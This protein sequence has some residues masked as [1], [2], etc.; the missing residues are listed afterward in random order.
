MRRVREQNGFFLK[1]VLFFFF[2][3][4]HD[5]D[6][7]SIR[8]DDIRSNRKVRLCEITNRMRTVRIVLYQL[9]KPLQ[10]L[11]II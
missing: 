8:C 7:F 3:L 2:D 9:L 11:A 4:L 10:L 5:Y 6:I 1:G